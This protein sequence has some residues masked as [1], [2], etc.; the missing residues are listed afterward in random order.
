[1]IL[2]RRFLAAALLLL[3]TTPAFAAPVSIPVSGTADGSSRWYEY[4]SDAFAQLDQGFSGDPALDGFFLI[5]A[6]PT[7]SP[8]GGGAD[9]FPN[10]ENFDLGSIDYDDAGL[11]GNGIEVTPITGYTV[12][13]A[14]N[15]A[16]NDAIVNQ[17]YTTA[18]QN[19]SGTLTF[20]NGALSAI[21]MTS[22]IIFSYD[23]SGFGGSLLDFSGDFAFTGDSF[24]LL[25]DNE[26]YPSGLPTD[27]KYVWESTGAIDDLVPI[28]EPG[29][30][31][32]LTIGGVA[33]ASVG[34][35][36]VRRQG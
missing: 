33:L 3:I 4:F 11:N 35:R 6:L 12:D 36:R 26:S 30:L 24:E 16:D 14:Q 18:L 10:E 32:L 9:V 17:P 22:D 2:L 27:I 7:L 8:I 1:M 34:L 21:N 20:F 15:I 13:F 23:F 28:P 31:L 19:V 5:S 29:S 25:V